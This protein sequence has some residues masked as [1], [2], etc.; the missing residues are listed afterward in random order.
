MLA[1]SSLVNSSLDGIGTIGATTIEKLEGTPAPGGVVID[2]LS[3]PL[4]PLPRLPLLPTPVSPIPV[5]SPLFIY[6]VNPVRRSGDQRRRNVLKSD[7]AHIVF[8]VD[9]AS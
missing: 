3:F 8:L 1:I 6:P 4:L 9:A 2:S 7:T 5:L